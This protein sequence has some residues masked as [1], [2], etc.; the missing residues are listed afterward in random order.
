MK[1]HRIRY[2]LLIFFLATA[3]TVFAHAFYV[4]ICSIEENPET[5]TF[6]MTYRVFT[7]DLEL[8]L[9]Q[10][11]GL[12]TRLGTSKEYASAD[13]LMFAYLK[14][15]FRIS[16]N[17]KP[18][19]LKWIGREVELDVTWNYVEAPAPEKIERI[20]V[21]NRLLFEQH[22]EQKNIV[23]ITSTKGKKSMILQ[24]GK[25]KDEVRFE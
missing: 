20:E 9:D 22:K 15:V 5:M 11:N 1:I 4:S 21:E 6:E 25:G 10:S 14:D 8:A 7:D 23:N 12:K 2:F 3:A 17:G 13:S 19:E 16:V 24:M 18:V